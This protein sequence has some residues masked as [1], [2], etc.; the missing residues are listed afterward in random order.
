MNEKRFDRSNIGG[1]SSLKRGAARILLLPV[2]FS[3][4]SSSRDNQQRFGWTT[5]LFS[6]VKGVDAFAFHPTSIHTMN[7]RKTTAATS[8][9]TTAMFAAAAD[10]GALDVVINGNHVSTES[11]IS[12]PSTMPE[13]SKK[14]FENFDYE[15]HWYPCIWA[16]DLEVD[17]PTKVTIFDVDYVVAKTSKGE[18]I[19]M[20]DYCTHK[21]AALSEGRITA[22]GHFQCAYHGW[23]FDGKTGD[24]V[25][26]PQIVKNDGTHGKIPSRACSTAVPAQIY[27]DMVWLFPG[28]GLEKALA[29]PPPPSIPE[30]FDGF[31]KGF[32]VRDLPIDFAILLSNICD[33][34]HGPFAHQ[35]T[36]FDM[37]MA[38]LD[39]PFESFVSE[40]TDGGKGWVLKTK[41][42]SKDKIQ[43]TDRI[44]RERLNPKPKKSRNK[45][46]EASAS[47]TP[48]ATSLF[49]APTHVRLNR[50]DKETGEVNFAS[51][52]YVCPVGVGRSRFMTTAVSKFKVPKWLSYMVINN[53]LD[54]DTFLLATQQQNILP[55]EAEDLRT[56]MKEQG[57]DPSDKEGVK[58]L[59]MRTRRNIFCS[60]SPTER[61][62][63]N[64]D[65]FWDATLAKCPNRIKHLIRLDDSGAFLQAPS[66]EVVLDRKTQTFDLCK[67]VRDSVG[68]FGKAKKASR[69]LSFAL[70]LTKLVSLKYGQPGLLRP[71]LKYSSMGSAFT[72]FW[73]VSTLADKVEKEFH[74]KY[75]DSYRQKDMNKI[76]EKIWIDR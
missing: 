6:G 42:D 70:L 75:T 22:S 8:T 67:D 49:H 3:L 66:R 31:K 35:D 11:S 58:T 12:S 10:K 33:P 5:A 24:C 57:I 47:S 50:V 21:G 54:Q 13:H 68:R 4:L 40:E 45:K 69:V 61:I 38:S 76:P 16:E 19:A 9:T 60:P 48:W 64:I 15:D 36:N 71:L 7:S 32:F 17:E 41:V 73:V 25:E 34:D 30:E 2:L 43:E 55:K 18:V 26:I 56:M 37:Y 39:C 62:G 28:G 74:F 23:S 20:K 1:K 65:K 14:P 46:S 59:R 29:A 53:F 27:Q 51:V 52:F 44:R 72:L 63:A